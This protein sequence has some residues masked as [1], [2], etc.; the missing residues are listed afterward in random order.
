MI[1]YTAITNNYDSLRELPKGIKGICFTDNRELESDTWE[2]RYIKNLD[3]KEP[4]ILNHK[5]FPNQETMWIDGNVTLLKLPKT[6]HLATFKAKDYQ[7]AYIEARRCRG[8]KDTPEHI[9]AQ[10]AVMKADDY[11]KNNGL[12][13]CSV[14]I[15]DGKGL[16]DFEKLWWKQ[17][18]RTRRDQVSFNY[19]LWKLG[20]KQTHLE[21]T[22]YKN[23]Y[24]IW[25]ITHGLG[26]HGRIRL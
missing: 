20:I 22:I 5:Y 19:C 7:C 8:G 14:I 26:I 12:S 9:D 25:N 6:S 11:P 10:V 17:L 1:V 13:A 16:E 23:E 4:K 21:G 15:R 24:L 2:I 18:K 3:H